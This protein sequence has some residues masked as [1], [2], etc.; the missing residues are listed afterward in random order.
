MKEKHLT[1]YRLTPSV[2]KINTPTEIT[3]TALGENTAFIDG[4]DNELQ[5]W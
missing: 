1:N 4:L 5:I 3:I 2:V